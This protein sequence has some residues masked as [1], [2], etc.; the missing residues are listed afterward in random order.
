M[1][2]FIATGSARKVHEQMYFDR[3]DNKKGKEPKNKGGDSIWDTITEKVP[4]SRPK[5][6]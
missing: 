5:K 6:R 3:M 4:D 1:A 2:K